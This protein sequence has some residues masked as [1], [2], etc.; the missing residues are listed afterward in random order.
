MF[1]QPFF[2]LSVYRFS[3]SMIVRL[4]FIT[5][6]NFMKSVHHLSS[7]I[8]QYHNYTLPP[9]VIS[10]WHKYDHDTLSPCVAYFWAHDDHDTLPPQVISFRT[11]CDHGT[12]RYFLY[13]LFNIDAIS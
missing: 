8:F 9:H 12:V 3:L 1:R 2:I 11:L 10:F 6:I 4:L 7:L 13:A 5:F